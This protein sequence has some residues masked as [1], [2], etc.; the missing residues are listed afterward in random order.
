MLYAGLSESTPASTVT[1]ACI[2]ANQAVTTGIGY[3]L[4]GNA[5]VFIA[6]GAETMSDVPIRYPRSMRKKLLRLN[7]KKK[8]AEKLGLVGSIRPKDFA[9]EAPAVAEFTSGE[10]MGHSSDRLASAFNVSR[11]EQDDY[12]IRSHTFAKNATDKGYLNDIIRVPVPNK[13]AVATEDE[14][15]RVSTKE[16]LAKLRPAFIR[17]HGSITAANA[18]FLV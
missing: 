6:G 13:D 14:G 12:A 8:L 3:I 7:K 4:S 2:S 10:V 15:I 1:M 17:P 11:E 16:Q 18:S 5:E 9:P